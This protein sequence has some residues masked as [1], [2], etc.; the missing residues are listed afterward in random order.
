[1]SSPSAANAWVTA[2]TGGPAG[3]DIPSML[4]FCSAS[5]LGP[6]PIKARS[7]ALSMS[8]PMFVRIVLF[9]PIVPEFCRPME[10]FFP[11]SPMKSLTVPVSAYSDL[12]MKCST[13]GQSIVIERRSRCGPSASIGPVPFHA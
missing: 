8:T 9:E 3:V 1:M 10:T 12:T 13:L 2:P 7:N 5:A 11:C 4:P 6:Y